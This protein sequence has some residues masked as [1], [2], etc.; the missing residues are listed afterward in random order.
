MQ[1]LYSRQATTTSRVMMTQQ[2]VLFGGRRHP[3]SVTQMLPWIRS[4]VVG[5]AQQQLQDVKR[6][7]LSPT[8]RI[9]NSFANNHH[10]LRRRC[11]DYNKKALSSLVRA[12]QN[13][14]TNECAHFA[15]HKR[16]SMIT[17]K[18]KRQSSTNAT[19]TAASEAAAEEQISS[20]D[21]A[22][23]LSQLLEQP[24]ALE[25]FITKEMTMS[26]RK[27]IQRLLQSSK[28]SVDVPE[29]SVKALRLVAFNTSIP[30]VSRELL[31]WKCKLS[32]KLL[33]LN[34]CSRYR[35]DSG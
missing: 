18:K 27:S 14:K 10:H 19:T 13:C 34:S 16:R 22:Q 17:M 24:L 32:L 1:S 33:Y 11:I 30:F 21:T 28:I 12:T 3:Q 5:R 20:E 9:N 23:Q 4:L 15:R 31:R 2:A 29:P 6:Q 25:S 7:L 35:W 26:Q 8:M